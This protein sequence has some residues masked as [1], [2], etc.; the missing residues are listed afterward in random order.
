MLMNSKWSESQ[1][2]KIVL[3]ESPACSAVFEVFLKYLYTG[4][5]AQKRTLLFRIGIKTMQIRIRFSV[6]CRSGSGPGSCPKFY[7]CWKIIIFVSFMHS[8]ASLLCFIFLVSVIGGKIFNIHFEP[9]KLL[10][11]GFNSGPGSDTTCYSNKD[12]DLVSQTNAYP[13]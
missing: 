1:E 13:W 2:K 7:T 4:I 6:W 5:R 8:S 11:F 10:N 3:R 12:P 9:L